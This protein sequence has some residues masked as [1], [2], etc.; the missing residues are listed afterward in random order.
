[1]RE[2][3]QRRLAARGWADWA[4]PLCDWLCGFMDTPLPLLNKEQPARLPELGQALG[5]MEFW[6][7]VRQLDAA[8]LD[9]LISAHL[10]PGQ[11]RPPLAAGTLAGMI[12]G[13]IDL[14]FC[15]TGRYGVADYKFHSLGPDAAAYAL[16]ALRAVMLAHRYDVQAALYLL[17]LHRLL[18]ARLPGY[19][20]ARHLGGAAYC[21]VRGI[22]APGRGVVALP[23]PPALI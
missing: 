13:Y 3:A 6:L 15:Q 18:R 23:A 2:Q 12:R 4:D 20:I 1:L 17:A 19:D 7:P 11:P 16:P 5:E 8:R 14:S 9:T 10:W 22:G 21:F